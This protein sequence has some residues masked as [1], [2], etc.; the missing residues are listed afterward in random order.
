MKQNKLLEELNFLKNE[1]ISFLKNNT[2]IHKSELLKN[3]NYD[4]HNSS[5]LSQE[6]NKINLKE[7]L[8][9][10]KE[11]LKNFEKLL[12]D[13]DPDSK[14]ILLFI[15]NKNNIWELIKRN[16][17]KIETLNSSHELV[18]YNK[19]IMDLRNDKRLM[20]ENILDIHNSSFN[21]SDLDISK[22]SDCNLSN[23]VKETI[24]NM[25]DIY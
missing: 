6:I 1:L 4:S 8:E 25:S 14:D 19:L 21:N 16:D 23:I 7:N 13:Y 10:N 15:D 12:N 20:E 11:S 18:S 9:D 24:N 17:L 22:G 3:K 5:L 2:A